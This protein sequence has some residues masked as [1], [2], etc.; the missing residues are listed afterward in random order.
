MSAI[1]NGKKINGILNQKAIALATHHQFTPSSMRFSDLGKT[2]YHP[3]DQSPSSVMA[4][5][6][7]TQHEGSTVKLKRRSIND[8][9]ASNQ[10]VFPHHTSSNANSKNLNDSQNLLPSHHNEA[11]LYKRSEDAL[12]QMKIFRKRRSA[13]L[14]N[15][16]YFIFN[17]K[18][19]RVYDQTHHLYNPVLAKVGP[20]KKRLNPLETNMS[21]MSFDESQLG[22][23]VGTHTPIAN[24]KLLLNH[25]SHVSSIRDVF[26][27]YDSSINRDQQQE[28]REQRERRE[29]YELLQKQKMREL[30]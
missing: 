4:M 8:H 22:M 13:F 10:A 3:I 5:Q 24:Q 20:S 18:K 30:K 19:D 6:R 12:N 7:I 27:N 21:K 1:K 15:G 28:L 2:I 26:P 11:A 16:L 9:V 14:K 23:T 29:Q 17:N 25:P